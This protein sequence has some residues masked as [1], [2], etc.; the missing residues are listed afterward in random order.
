MECGDCVGVLRLVYHILCNLWYATDGPGAVDAGSLHQDA[1]VFD[2]SRRDPMVFVCVGDGLA[3][4]TS[5]QRL[6]TL[7][8]SFFGQHFGRK[9]DRG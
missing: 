7:I 1:R 9:F 8:H 5:K 2:Q 3:S 6:E 4:I